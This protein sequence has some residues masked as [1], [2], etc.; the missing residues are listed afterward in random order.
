MGRWVAKT[1]A[2]LICTETESRLVLP[3]TVVG[4]FRGK[5]G[6][7]ANGYKFLLEGVEILCEGCTMLWIH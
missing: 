5:W 3:R 2:V 7:I 4:E 1:A 6:V